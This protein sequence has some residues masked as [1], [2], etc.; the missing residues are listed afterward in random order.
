MYFQKKKFLV[1][2]TRSQIIILV[3]IYN[4]LYGKPYSR[5][6]ERQPLNT[7]RDFAYNKIRYTYFI[8]LKF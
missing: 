8:S 2:K 3:V 7:Q 1:R 5:V 4:S 6:L